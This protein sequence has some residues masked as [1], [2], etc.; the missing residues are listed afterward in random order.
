[1]VLKKM[2]IGLLG[3]GTVGHS[4][5]T[6][7]RDN[8]K[9]IQ[10]KTGCQVEIV[11]IAVKNLTKKRDV[12]QSLLT[13]QPL[14]VVENQNVD[15]IIELMGDCEEAYLA[16]KSALQ[17]GKPVVTANKAILAKYGM[18]L[19]ALAEK[20]KTEI[21]FEASVAGGI[22]ILRT[23]REGITCNRI[24]ALKGII[25][26]TANF[27]L[28]EMSQK[29][30]SFHE[31]LKIAQDR[32]YAEANP[33]SD[34]EGLDSAYKL[35]I[36]VMLCHGRVIRQDQLFIKGIDYIKP[37]DIDMAKQFGYVIKLLGITKEDDSGFEARVHPTMILS[38]H[39]LAHVDGAHNAI[40]YVG[41]YVGEG[42]QYG[43]GAGGDP[44][45]S[46]VVSDLIEVC[47]REK[48][49][50][51]PFLSATGF[52]TEHLKQEAPKDILQ[53]NTQ[54]YLRF[55]VKDE[56]HVLAQVTRILGEHHISIKHVFQQGSDDLSEIPLIVFTHQT[57]EKNVRQALKQIDQLD[58]VTQITKL[59]R[60][61]E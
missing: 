11:H 22:P 47:R 57:Q 12:S 46:A 32:G 42:M 49:G 35:M 28:S 29:G 41:D 17:K 55:S 16:I 6:I 56:P 4:V 3:L 34:V 14:A 27:I 45:A 31:A 59:I 20:H 24:L 54:Y 38:S 30:L 1:M 39:P 51:T 58:F 18:E 53:L 21:L 25:N 60:I 40:S 61:E 10:Q 26:G 44:T 13:D 5:W 23:L 8:Q 2:N 52:A 33:A 19:F 7:I 9:R 15:V 36:L 48:V 37:I 43:L 50:N